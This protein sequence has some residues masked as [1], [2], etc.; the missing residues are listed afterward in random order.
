LSYRNNL[1][2]KFFCSGLKLLPHCCLHTPTSLTC[3]LQCCW[4]V[5]EGTPKAVFILS[6]T[7]VESV[8]GGHQVSYLQEVTIRYKICLGTNINKVCQILNSYY[9]SC[10]PQLTQL[11]DVF[12]KPEIFVFETCLTP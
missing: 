5:E 10:L 6:L 1:F 4:N 9:D 7:P 3:L 12:P 8:A 11:R 2:W